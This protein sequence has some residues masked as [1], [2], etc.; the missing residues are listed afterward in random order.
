MYS[1]QIEGNS[2]SPED[3]EQMTEKDEKQY[4]RQ[5]VENIISALTYL[6]DKGLPE[7]IDLP[8]FLHLHKMVMHKLVHKS[9]AGFY[10]KN[11]VLFL[12]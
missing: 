9:Q 4:E 5:M 11:L 2:L 8:F 7:N 1:A 3:Y 6:R 10:E 12:M